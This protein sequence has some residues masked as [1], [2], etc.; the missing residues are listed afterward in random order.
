[1][2]DTTD[3]AVLIAELDTITA[4]RDAAADARGEWMQAHAA[5][6]AR[7][8][9]GTQ[10]VDF[11]TGKIIGVV[12]RHSWADYDGDQPE[13]GCIVESPDT[14]YVVGVYPLGDLNPKVG[15]RQERRAWLTAQLLETA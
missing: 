3:R 13:V 6:F 14:R 1:M 5:A 4:A 2:I 10:I 11:A 8:P 12:V 15:T 7:W 9:I